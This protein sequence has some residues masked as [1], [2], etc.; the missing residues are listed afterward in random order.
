MVLSQADLDEQTRVIKMHL[1]ESISAIRKE[2]IAMLNIENEKLR[3]KI[4]SLESRNELLETRVDVLESKMET[5]LQYQRNASVV[6]AGIPKDIDHNKLEGTVVTIFNS[7]CFHSI[8]HREI[9][10]CHRLSAKTDT[11]LV[12]FGNKKD[13]SALLNSK[14]SIKELDKSLIAPGCTN[15]YINEHLTPFMSELAYHCR[16]LK[17][18][19]KIYQTKVENGIVKVLTNIEGSFRWFNITNN[20]DINKLKEQNNV[21]AN[22]SHD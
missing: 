11:V 10:A 16:C 9:I 6:I 19:K 4:N 12:Q 2:V 21:I 22:E 20:N 1:D 15:L 17:R 7:V 8:T 18:E 14:L 3:D 5:N 13:A